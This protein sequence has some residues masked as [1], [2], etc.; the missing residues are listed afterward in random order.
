MSM[1]TLGNKNRN[2]SLKQP[3]S[4]KDGRTKQ[5][6]KDETD[7][8][9]IMAR[10]EKVGTISHLDKYE[11]IYTDYSDYDFMEQTQMLTKGREIF[12]DLPAEVRKEFSQSPA[13]FFAFVNNPAN[14]DKLREKLPALAA[15]GRQLPAMKQETADMASS[16]AAKPTPP[17]AE[18]AAPPA[19]PPPPAE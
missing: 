7:I 1:P 12:D 15:P 5:S 18:P 8:Q 14:L 3:Q 9:K 19:T 17:A 11:G 2:G 4:Y 10:A 16:E 13:E 6:Y